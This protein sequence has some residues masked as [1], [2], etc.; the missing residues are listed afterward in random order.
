MSQ[1]RGRHAARLVHNHTIYH[2]I[3]RNTSNPFIR[4]TRYAN[5]WLFSSRVFNNLLL[6]FEFFGTR[7]HVTQTMV[8]SVCVQPQTVPL[9]GAPRQSS[10][11]IHDGNQLRPC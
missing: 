5:V 7:L 3:S 4:R 11:N 10:F 2:Q 1:N 9:E 8:M 6:T